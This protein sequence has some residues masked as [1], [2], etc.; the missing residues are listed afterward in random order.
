M[1]Q[2][3]KEIIG[4]WIFF[5]SGVN[6]YWRIYSYIFQIIITEDKNPLAQ[7]KLLYHNFYLNTEIY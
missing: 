1:I 7:L 3:R 2:L 4:N 6:F 5:V